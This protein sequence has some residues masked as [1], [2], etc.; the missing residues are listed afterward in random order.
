MDGGAGIM[1]P[2]TLPTLAKWRKNL[3][4]VRKLPVH[5]VTRWRIVIFIRYIAHLADPLLWYSR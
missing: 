2:L 1:A 5:P 3:S 4:L